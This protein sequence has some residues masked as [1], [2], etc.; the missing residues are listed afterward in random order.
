MKRSLSRLIYVLWFIALPLTGLIME[1]TAPPKPVMYSMIALEARVAA[2]LPSESRRTFFTGPSFAKTLSF[3]AD[4]GSLCEA[5]PGC[6]RVYIIGDIHHSS[7]LKKVVVLLLDTNF[8]VLKTVESYYD[9]E[10]SVSALRKVREMVESRAA[11]L[12]PSEATSP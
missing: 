5:T 11:L 12:I 2:K 1:L 4:V 10:Y 9:Q 6:A 7:S 8:K 3:W